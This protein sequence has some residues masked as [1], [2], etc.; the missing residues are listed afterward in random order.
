MGAGRAGGEGAG[1]ESGGRGTG[2]GAARRLGLPGAW[3]WGK[4][5]GECFLDGESERERE[6]QAEA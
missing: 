4:R 3:V 6:K 5:K 1:G 2:G